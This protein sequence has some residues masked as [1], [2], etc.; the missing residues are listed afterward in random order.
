MHIAESTPPPLDNLEERPHSAPLVR[1]EE[2]G[3]MSEAGKST[4][5]ARILEASIGEL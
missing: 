2:E 4:A 3:R 5:I 1:P